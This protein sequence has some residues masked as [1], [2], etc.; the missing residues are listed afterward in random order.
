[1]TG[2]NQDLSGRVAVVTGASQGIGRAIAVALAHAGA[3]VWVVARRAGVLEDVARTSG[4]P[5]S[6]RIRPCAVDLT[7]DHAVDELT[8]RIDRCDIL[9]HC[10]GSHEVAAMTE[11]SIDALDAMF[12][13]N[14]RA[15]YR[16]TQRLLPR[17]TERGGDVVF[18]NS[19]QGLRGSPGRTQFAATQHAL[20][21]MADVMRAELGDVGVRV[22]SVFP[23]RTAT[24]R[25]AA[26][27]E[28]E[29]RP[30]VPGLLVQPD[31]IAR[32]VIETLRLPRHVELTELHLRPRAKSY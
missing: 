11:A 7:D 25:M 18:L 8:S 4:A 27:F 20:K 32:M 30:Y 10:A 13:I 24:P 14:V 5:V 3:D 22:L 16:L 19:T 28:Q 29:G 9:V 6:G 21:G 17:L 26:L 15:P 23:G 1:V 2:A 31:D 12:R